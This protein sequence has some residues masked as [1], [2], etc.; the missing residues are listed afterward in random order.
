M[1]R[2]RVPRGFTI[3]ELLVVLAIIMWMMAFL[4][5]ALR[6]VRNQVRA[7]QCQNNLAQVARAL[8]GYDADF[9][10]L[11]AQQGTLTDTNDEYYWTWLQ[12][13]DRASAWGTENSRPRSG[14]LYKYY[15]DEAL[16]LCPVDVDGNGVFSY[17]MPRVLGFRSLKNAERP[18]EQLM[19]LQEDSASI[20]EFKNG[21]FIGDDKPSTL[22]QGLTPTA[23]LDGHVDMYDWR[24]YPGY[25]NKLTGAHQRF[26]GGTTP[27][28]Y[29]G[30]PEA[31]NI[32][33]QP[34]GIADARSGNGGENPWN[35]PDQSS[36]PPRYCA[37]D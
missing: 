32:F 31:W 26:P 16:V 19:I 4:A 24:Q 10:R 13:D 17:T 23:F 1:P 33:V 35:N 21:S 5:P 9:G 37:P 22:H 34:W 28:G 3:I 2:R 25:F 29:D 12:K 27:P 11:P 20:N 15:G 8:R 30:Q 36:F 6:S 7:T 14:M 18:A